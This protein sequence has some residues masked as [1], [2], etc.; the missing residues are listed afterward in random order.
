MPSMRIAIAATFTAEP[1]ADSLR[2]WIDKLELPVTFQFADYNQV[3]QQLL[4]P[5]SALAGNK[6][7]LN[8]LLLR[9]SD[10]ERQ[11]SERRPKAMRHGVDG[12]HV[13]RDE[14][15]CPDPWAARCRLGRNPPPP[16][17]SGYALGWRA[18]GR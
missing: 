2:F 15:P 12:V 8:V 5:T 7:G 1:L 3:F 18:R 11:A 9:L 6:N 16:R 14:A 17:R 10:W 4:D 13:V